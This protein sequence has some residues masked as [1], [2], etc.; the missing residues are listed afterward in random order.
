MEN[1]TY[2]Y[3]FGNITVTGSKEL[4]DQIRKEQAEYARELAAKR[5]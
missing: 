1:K 5:S 4:I 2:T 3:T